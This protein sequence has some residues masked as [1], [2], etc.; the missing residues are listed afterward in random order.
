MRLE[1]LW[2]PWHCQGM[3]H[4]RLNVDHDGVFAESQVS[5]HQA[6]FEIRYV[7]R[8]DAAW[9]TRAVEV[10][11]VDAHRVLRLRTDGEGHWEGHPELEGCRDVDLRCTP[12]T[13]SLPI[14]R[15]PEGGVVRAAWIGL[16]L[17]IEPLE[18]RY[19][20]L[21][22]RRWH[23]RTGDFERELEVDEHGLVIDYPD[24]WRRIRERR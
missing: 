21:G 19:T 7:V 1:V 5:D 12:F 17:E 22:E 18:Q 6:G 24:G 9:R 2:E 15:Q 8:A 23:Y 14:H 20:P 13:N 11:R 10:A 4:L 16:D 3:E